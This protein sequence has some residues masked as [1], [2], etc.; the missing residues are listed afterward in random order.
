MQNKDLLY[1]IMPDLV[2]NIGV[3]IKACKM[4]QVL[5]ILFLLFANQPCVALLSLQ[6]PVATLKPK[7]IGKV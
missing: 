3:A 7:L 5:K 1:V 4:S 6:F 2:G